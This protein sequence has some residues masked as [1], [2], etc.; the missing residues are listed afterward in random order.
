MHRCILSTV[1]TDGLVLK[2]QA[3]STHNADY[4]YTV[5]NQFHTEISLLYVGMII[6]NKNNIAFWKKDLVV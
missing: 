3:I 6:E 5:L 2:H 4:T 1:A